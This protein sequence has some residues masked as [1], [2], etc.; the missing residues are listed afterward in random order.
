M[1]D[2]QNQ[3]TDNMSEKLDQ[4]NNNQGQINYLLVDV[5]QRVIWTLRQILKALK[6]AAEHPPIAQHLKGIDLDQLEQALKDAEY[7]RKRV[8]D[9]S[10]PGCVTPPPPPLPPP[11]GGGP[12]G[13]QY[14][15]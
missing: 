5:D 10:P 1:S 11:P 14:P 2:N 6:S 3:T 8:A 13:S 4:T 15:E 7:V 12:G 9:I